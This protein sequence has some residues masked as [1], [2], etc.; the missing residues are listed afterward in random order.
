MTSIPTTPDPDH[1]DC[2]EFVVPHVAPEAQSFSYRRFVKLRVS[3]L[4]VVLLVVLGSISLIAF[5]GPRV[6][7]ESGSWLA[8]VL[9][10]VAAVPL[11]KRLKSRNQLILYGLYAVLILGHSIFFDWPLDPVV[12]QIVV[13]CL[14]VIFMLSFKGSEMAVAG[15]VGSGFFFGT[16]SDSDHDYSIVGFGIALLIASLVGATM[17]AIGTAIKS[18]RGSLQKYQYF[19][20]SVPLPMWEV[21]LR[22][23]RELVAS[24]RSQGVS[25]FCF[26]MDD[27]EEL[28]QETWNRLVV[29]EVNPVGQRLLPTTGPNSD[30]V[31]V[32]SK[33][34]GRALMIALLKVFWGKGR[35]DEI[36]V[37]FGEGPSAQHYRFQGHGVGLAVGDVSRVTVVAS[38]VSKDKNHGVELKRQIV[39]RERFVASIAHEI[40]T[41]LSTVV[42]LAQ[43]ILETPEMDASERSELLDLMIRDGQDLAGIVEDLLVGA[44]LDM[45]TL[46]IVLQDVPVRSEIDSVLAA[47]GMRAEV[48]GRPGVAVVGNRI[49]FRQVVRNMLTNA[50]RY[51]GSEVRVVYGSNGTTGFVEVRDNGAAVPLEQRE[52]MFRAYERLHDRPGVTES[53]GLGLP[54]SRSLARAMGG[55]LEY[56]HDGQESIFRVSL[57]VAKTSR[58]LI[59]VGATA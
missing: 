4:H 25:D 43:S 54:V 19:V 33:P 37:S 34:L 3:W 52:K 26:H 48:D 47:L 15:I 50:G 36:G 31:S 42:G 12:A 46:K 30:P 6:G 56:D 22:G 20:D 2:V 27:N 38:D 53:V 24:L 1:H 28:L 10:G 32:I 21:D 39:N 14:G 16:I 9:A 57:P 7:I 41:P 49:R 18:E 58:L 11:L 44:R 29:L 40:R 59:E 23:I 51:G 35:I 5:S 55:D 13:G 8:L 45:G 17:A